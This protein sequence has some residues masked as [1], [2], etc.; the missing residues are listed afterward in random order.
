MK[1][2]GKEKVYYI[3][4]NNIVKVKVAH[5]VLVMVIVE[6]QMDVLVQIVIIL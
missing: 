5:V 3:V 6:Q 4:E 2:V 1:E